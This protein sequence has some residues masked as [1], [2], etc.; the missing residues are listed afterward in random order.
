MDGYEYM[1]IYTH[2]DTYLFIYLFIFKSL[3]LETLKSRRD[4]VLGSLLWV[5][6]LEQRLDEMDTESLSFCN[7][8]RVE[9]A[10][11][12]FFS[13]LLTIFLLLVL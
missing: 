12:S 3:T 11:G 5:P 10:D 1:T 4:V 2:M 8:S 7:I 9:D 13:N 6:L